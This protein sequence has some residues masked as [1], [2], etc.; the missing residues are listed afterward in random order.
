MLLRSIP[1]GVPVRWHRRKV[2]SSTEAEVCV[3]TGGI[4]FPGV[5]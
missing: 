3:D 4:H 2:V 1:Y 5:V